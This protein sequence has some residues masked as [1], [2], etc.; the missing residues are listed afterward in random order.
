MVY[1]RGAGKDDLGDILT[2]LYTGETRVHKQR[3]DT[4]LTLARSLG[5]RG[6]GDKEEDIEIIQD[7]IQDDTV[8][9]GEDKE[10][11]LDHNTKIIKDN[12]FEITQDDGKD[13]QG[14]RYIEITEEDEFKMKHVN[15]DKIITDINMY[16]GNVPQSQSVQVY[17]EINIDKT[18]ICE[19]NYLTDKSNISTK[20]NTV[21][22]T[23]T[24]RKLSPPKNFA[25]RLYGM[26]GKC[27]YCGE[28]IDGSTKQM[29]QHLLR[30]H[31]DQK[32]VL[33][34]LTYGVIPDTAK[35]NETKTID[36]V[37]GT[38]NGNTKQAKRTNPNT[39]RIGKS[40]VWKYF[41]IGEIGKAKCTLCSFVGTR[42]GGNTTALRTHLLKCHSDNQ[43]VLADI[44]P[45]V[46]QADIAFLNHMRLKKPL[47]IDPISNPLENNAM[48]IN[49]WKYFDTDH[50]N[51]Y[52]KCKLC[53]YKVLKIHKGVIIDLRNHLSSTHP[54]TIDT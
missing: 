14:N 5:V 41:E 44:Q 30:Y 12:V 45:P 20:P 33:D 29:D 1:L 35:L 17:N 19:E 26:N 31:Y 46:T 34:Y 54:E 36:S 7:V 2:F 52:A 16:D 47:N 13:I 51:S 39:G 27:N 10:I 6:F 50:A 53:L 32:Y 9:M 43:E 49:E 42:T 48:Q 38:K 8:E 23:R 3:L 15:D 25:Q 40:P 24:K 18:Q 4:F 37:V 28:T 11:S 21:V 22:E